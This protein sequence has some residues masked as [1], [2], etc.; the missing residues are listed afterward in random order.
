MRVPA[1]TYQKDKNYKKRRPG[2]FSVTKRITSAICQTQDD[3]DPTIV[4]TVYRNLLVEQYPKEVSLAPMVEKDFASDKPYDDF[5][6]RFV[7][8]RTQS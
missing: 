6:K 4:K 8:R 5:C 2:P 1:K 7:E 3:R